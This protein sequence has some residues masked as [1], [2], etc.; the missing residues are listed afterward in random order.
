MN[1][2]LYFVGMALIICWAL[3]AFN[4]GTTNTEVNHTEKK[5]G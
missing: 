3:G 2:F 4:S 1:V 5:Q